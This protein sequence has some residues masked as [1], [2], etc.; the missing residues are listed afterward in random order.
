LSVWDTRNPLRWEAPY[1]VGYGGTLDTSYISGPEGDYAFIE[2]QLNG[3]SPTA[4]NHHDR[5]RLCNRL[6]AA[7][8]AYQQVIDSVSLR[9]WEWYQWLR[10]YGGSISGMISFNYDLLV[11]A[12][13]EQLAIPFRRIGVPAE[14]NGFP[15]FKPH[16]S[17]D[18]GLPDY[19]VEEALEFSHQYQSALV[20]LECNHYEA[21]PRDQLGGNRFSCDLVLPTERNYIE[22]YQFIR[23]GYKESTASVSGIRTLVIVGVSYWQPDRRELDRICDSV[24]HDATVFIINPH[25]NEEWCKRLTSQGRRVVCMSDPPVI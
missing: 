25:P 19:V 3:E 5:V 12:T 24:P 4:K 10:K 6:I 18:F 15:I 8:G 7:F 16:G 22:H 1:K 13:L 21:I 11:E 2:R 17:V 14:T 20:E 23:D 9:G